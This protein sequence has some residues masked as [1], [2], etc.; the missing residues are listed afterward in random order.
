MNLIF[1]SSIAS[2]IKWEIPMMNMIVKDETSSV[3]NVKEAE[4]EVNV[5]DGPSETGEINFCPR[6][7]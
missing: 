6:L 1:L 5:K 2:K 3:A 7:L 4:A